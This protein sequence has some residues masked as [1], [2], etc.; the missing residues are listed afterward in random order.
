MQTISCFIIYQTGLTKLHL[1][2]WCSPVFYFA[3]SKTTQ[4]SMV[5]P[6][7]PF[8]M[9]K[10]LW[11]FRK[12]YETLSAS[13]SL[14][15]LLLCLLQEANIEK[16]YN[17]C[18]QQPLQEDA[19]HIAEKFNTVFNLLAEKTMTPKR[20]SIIHTFLCSGENGVNS[21]QSNKPANHPM[22][23]SRTIQKHNA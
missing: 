9:T 23:A 20:F 3:S 5:K 21:Q 17:S 14:S 4:A 2:Q 16:P 13:P 18:V 8:C 15:A 10:W 6:N 7:L 12:K 1:Y 19:Q 11:K 22:H